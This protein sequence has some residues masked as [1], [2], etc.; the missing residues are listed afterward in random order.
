MNTKTESFSVWQ[1]LGLRPAGWWSLIL[2]LATAAAAPAMAGGSAR[3]PDPHE[4]K[5]GDWVY[6]PVVQADNDKPLTVAKYLGAK[7][8][9]SPKT[10]ERGD[11][12]GR[13]GVVVA[14][15]STETSH[16]EFKLGTFYHPPT[17]TLAIPRA[18]LL[19]CPPRQGP[20]GDDFE[21]VIRIWKGTDS[22]PLEKQ[23]N[24][25]GKVGDKVTVELKD[26]DRWLFVQLDYGKF[27]EDIND[28]PNELR[29]HVEKAVATRRAKSFFMGVKQV[30][31]RLRGD[32]KTS[33]KE[34]RKKAWDEL[35]EIIKKDPI[36]HEVAEGINWEAADDEHGALEQE[37]VKLEAKF[38]Q[39]MQWS[40]N[41]VDKRF[42][43][44]TLAFNGVVLKGMKPLNAFNPTGIGRSTRPSFREDT[45]YWLCFDLERKVVKEGAANVRPDDVANAAAWARLLGRPKLHEPMRVT[46]I[47]PEPGLVLP[48]KVNPDI[49]DAPHFDLI[50]IKAS[51]LYAALAAF[52][53]LLTFL[54][55]L[56]RKTNILRDS[57]GNVRPDGI[58]P[59]SLAKTQM[60]F[61]FILTALAFAFLWVTTGDHNTIN[62]TCLVI[63]GIGTTTALGAAFV[64]SAAAIAGA[65]NYLVTAPID[66]P[67]AEIEGHIHDAIVE[68][69][70]QLGARINAADHDIR[71]RIV[72]LLHSIVPEERLGSVLAEFNIGEREAAAVSGTRVN[73]PDT[74]EAIVKG[75]TP[76]DTATETRGPLA[77]LAQLGRQK[78]DFHAMAK[79]SLRRLFA[80]WL[81]ENP[82]GDA[83]DFHRFQMLAWTLL[84]GL[85]FIVELLNDRAMPEFSDT[86]LT[87]LGISGGT[88]VGFK[89]P[90][91][92][93]AKKEASQAKEKA[94]EEEKK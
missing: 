84:L 51:V 82:S 28:V 58:E 6:F 74:I 54:G 62:K 67:R 81:S 15:G 48:S 89:L 11:Y 52:A 12:S 88:Y 1:S 55:W 78:R 20:V 69:L 40:L 43:D 41:F 16:V 60:A 73:I 38:G 76:A 21:G 85:V 34:V 22:T 14:G 32:M 31:Q 3:E 17:V 79:T 13:P 86:T 36:L 63:L 25:E 10:V 66:Q 50:G 77:E 59:V 4:F 19:R 53:T 26:F 94:K 87:L 9:T 49:A 42:H 70:R 75:L 90:A 92:L 65:R 57:T 24:H 33:F 18:L 37:V 44:L 7:G 64:P 83:Y 72:A 30:S 45:Y 29:K 61:W 68:R 80:D 46:L 91:A 56:A 47:L 27:R 2:A 35:Q 8:A 5:E 93:A 39:L 71:K 23:T